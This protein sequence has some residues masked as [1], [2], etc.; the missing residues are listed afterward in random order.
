MIS[1]YRLRLL[2]SLLV[3]VPSGVATKFYGGPAAGWVQAHAG[4]VLYV[5]FWTA[6]VLALRPSLSGPM[7][8]AGVFVG[9]CLLEGLQGWHPAP[10]EAIR[11]T[12]VGHAVLGSTFSWWDVPHYV[13]GALLG[14]LLGRIL[15][16]K[17]ENG[18][19]QPE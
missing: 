3:L 7:A 14:G 16:P 19:Q 18:P 12:F 6:V 8:A 4:G 9:T 17:R 11:N 2:I 15:R 10:L 1:S 5:I 13:T